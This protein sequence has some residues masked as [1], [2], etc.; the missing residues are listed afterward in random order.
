ER[1]VESP[2]WHTV[3][4]GAE[5]RDALDA[6]GEREA[7]FQIL[8]GVKGLTS[9]TKTPEPVEK[10]VLRAKHGVT[11]FKD[12]TVRYDMT[13]L[14][15]TAVRPQELDVTA[16]QFR[17][18]GYDTDVD[19]EPLRHDD[20]LVELK[21]QDV[22]LSDGSAEHMLKTANFVDDLL[23]RFYDLPPFYEVEEREDLVGELVFGMAPH[24]SA[25][26]VGRVVGFTSAG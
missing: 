2:G 26:V 23:E 17:A 5:L 21:V 4:L 14:P 11:S 16:D 25:A 20:Q 18:L 7:A 1:E 24:T 6:V 22:V 19:G 10:G 15:V 13:D 12:G 9:A 8:K 3:D